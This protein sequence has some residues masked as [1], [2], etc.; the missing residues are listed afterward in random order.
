M[1]IKSIT[2]RPYSVNDVADCILLKL[3]AD[4]DCYVVNLKLQKL[5]YYVQAWNF[6]KNGDTFVKGDFEAWIHGPANRELYERFRE[7]KSLYS[8]IG[9]ED[10]LNKNAIGVL[11]E[12][13]SQFIDLI[14][15]NYASFN[16]SDLE[17]MTHK[18][19]PW[20]DARK[21]YG[22]LDRCTNVISKQSM[23]EYYGKRWKETN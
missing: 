5:V 17:R 12:E 16:A 19:Q 22:P 3:N 14:L 8:L 10:I 18:E 4:E 21:G 11:T 7:N 20:L 1:I 13:D 6:G 23:I 2:M 9:K 15:D